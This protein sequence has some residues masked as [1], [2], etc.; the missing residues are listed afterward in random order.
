MDD[1][2]INNQIDYLFRA[3]LLHTTFAK[4]SRSDH[5]HCEFCFL[6]FSNATE[7]LHV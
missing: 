3:K 7:D 1:W 4:S 2:R 5:E 6:K